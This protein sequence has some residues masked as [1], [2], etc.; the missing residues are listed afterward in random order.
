MKLD[1]YFETMA[2]T[3]LSDAVQALRD[4][5]SADALFGPKIRSA[6]RENL[7]DE[8][9]TVSNDEAEGRR[10]AYCRRALLVA[11]FSA[12]AY[13]NDF[14]Y[15]HWSGVDQMTLQKL[16]TVEKY[17]FLEKL[18]RDQPT[19]VRGRD[20]MQR[21]KW[22]F[23]RRDE[24]VHAVPRTDLTY[25]P[26]YHNPHDVAKAIVAVVDAASTLHGKP[27][28]RSMLAYAL[29][30]KNRLLDVRSQCG[31]PATTVRC[32]SRRRSD[33]AGSKARLG[34]FHAGRAPVWRQAGQPGR[35][36]ARFALASGAPDVSA[37]L[38]PCAKRNGRALPFAS[39]PDPPDR[40]GTVAA[41]QP[42]PS[43]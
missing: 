36:R 40:A 5:G 29:E 24:L 39:V 34:G 38:S 43:S 41:C 17:V 32:S 33:A 15:E 14:L 8:W 6:S 1:I 27:H 35:A 11:A 42:R 26:E 37:E 20:P 22:L 19:F 2:G 31:G 13:A 9:L 18:S 25:R 4:S 12:E 30:S 10:V 7:T 28:R 3:H 21:L 16:S 23:T